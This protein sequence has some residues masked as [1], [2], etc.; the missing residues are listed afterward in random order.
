MSKEK[1]YGKP[2]KE[3]RFT[4]EKQPSTKKRKEAWKKR[5]E[6]TALRDEINKLQGLT[7][8][9]IRAMHKD[10]KK[11]PEKYTVM[12]F[13]ALSYVIRMSNNCKYIFDYRDREEG[14]APMQLQHVGQV[15]IDHF[16]DISKELEEEAD[17]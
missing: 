16:F 6:K 13:N 9:K 15:E 8:Q 11:H 14:K 2:P 5:R 1:G 7:L 17:D 3:H 4:K 12:Q 10:M